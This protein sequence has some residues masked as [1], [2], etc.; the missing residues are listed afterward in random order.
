M[1]DLMFINDVVF[2]THCCQQDSDRGIRPRKLLPVRSREITFSLTWRNRPKSIQTEMI[3][4]PTLA[5]KEVRSDLNLEPW[6]LLELLGIG[7]DAHEV[8]LTF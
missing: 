6:A 3:L 2:R 7:N 4:F 5:R 1:T 8:I